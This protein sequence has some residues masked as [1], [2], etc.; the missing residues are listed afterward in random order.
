MEQ[1]LI[2]TSRLRQ[3]CWTSGSQDGEPVHLVHGNLTTGRFWKAMADRLPERL[4]AGRA[5]PPFVRADRAQ[6]LSH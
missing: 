1:R 3:H 2:D 5:R 4:P 6:A